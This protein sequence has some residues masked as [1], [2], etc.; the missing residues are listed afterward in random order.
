MCVYVCACVYVNVLACG[1]GGRGCMYV[2]V[3]ACVKTWAFDRC[4][5][6]FASSSNVD[7]QSYISYHYRTSSLLW[8]TRLCAYPIIKP[9]FFPSVRGTVPS[10]H[11]IPWNVHPVSIVRR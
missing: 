9:A 6:N 3:C 5:N 10:N 1:R 4:R 2:R 7:T 8:E 11:W